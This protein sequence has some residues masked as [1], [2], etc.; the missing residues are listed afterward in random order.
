[1]LAVSSVSIAFEQRE[2]GDAIWRKYVA[3]ALE[4]GQLLA[5]PDPIIIKQ[6]LSAIQEGVDTLHKG[7]SANKVVVE[8]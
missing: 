1:M 3:G 4:N 2:V 6:G 7:V 8:L 5:K